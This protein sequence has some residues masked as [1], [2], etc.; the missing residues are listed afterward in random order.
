MK[1]DTAS[2]SRIP[3]GPIFAGLLFGAGFAIGVGVMLDLVAWLTPWDGPARWYREFLQAGGWAYL[4]LWAL[5][6]GM[7]ESARRVDSR[8][9]RIG[10]MVTSAVLS[11]LPAFWRPAVPESADDRWPTSQEA[12]IRASRRWSYR[13]METVAKLLPL[14]R[15]PDVEVRQHAVLALGLNRVVTDI[16]RDLHA[17][18]SL[19]ADHP[20]RDSLRTRL[21]E[22]LSDS[23]PSVRAEAARAL[24]KA[25]RTFGSQPAAAETLAALLDRVRTSPAPGRIA[26]LAIDA[27]AAPIDADLDSAVLDFSRVTPDSSLARMARWALE[28][29]AETSSSTGAALGAGGP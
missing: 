6:V 17:Y 22:C 18:P 5:C 1:D 19:Y 2:S 3:L 7:F 24:W 20:L 26:W 15:D 11:F 23:V 14:S 8:R 16:E 21:I 27:A 4:P 10:L 25:P 28:R 9:L 12:K 29:S 13:S